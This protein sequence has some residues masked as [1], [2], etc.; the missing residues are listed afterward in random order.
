MR[1][2]HF[3]EYYP[4]LDISLPNDEV[5][6]WYTYLQPRNF[7]L[8]KLF[9]ILSDDEKIRL[10]KFHFRKDKEYFIIGRGILRLLLSAYVGIRPK[11]VKFYYGV[12]GKPFLNMTSNIN[13]NLSHSGQ[14]LVLAF[15]RN[16]MIG[17]DIEHI[18]SIDIQN[19]ATNFFS[20][21]EYK[22]FESINELERLISFFKWW[23]RKESYIKAIGK[24]IT[25]CLKEFDVTV[26]P[27]HEPKILNIR[28]DSMEADSWSLHDILIDPN[29]S[30]TVCIEK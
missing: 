18:E 11:D 16:K 2:F 24:G 8:D 19:I 7:H 23:T 20:Q 13:F 12:N 29:Y 30:C 9:Q 27:D 1:L 28:N 3:L 26:L 5:H 21:M 25:Q 22:M 17:V 15:T 4:Q 14:L 10:D 6:L